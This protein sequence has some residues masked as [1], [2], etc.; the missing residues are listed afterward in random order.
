MDT[1]MENAPPAKAPSLEPPS[2]QLPPPLPSLPLPLSTTTSIGTTTITNT[3]TVIQAATATT[4]TTALNPNQNPLIPSEPRGYCQPAKCRPSDLLLPLSTPL[5]I[6]CDVCHRD[7]STTLRLACTVC[8]DFDTCLPC[9]YE[10]V[11]KKVRELA[12]VHEL[13]STDIFAYSDYMSKQVPF[14]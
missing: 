14:S 5:T 13:V 2:G 3:A 6:E 12:H 8:P 4:P 1:Q 7:I 11:K 9:F 10:T